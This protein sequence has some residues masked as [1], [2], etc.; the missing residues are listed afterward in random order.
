MLYRARFVG[1]VFLNIQCWAVVFVLKGC[2]LL[3]RLVF[4]LRIL[5]FLLCDRKC[6]ESGYVK[7][8]Y[9]SF[10]CSYV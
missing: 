2:S 9:S 10:S 7:S 8:V 6:W 3:Q 1:G 5:C 4:V